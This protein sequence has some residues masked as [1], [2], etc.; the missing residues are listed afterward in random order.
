MYRQG[1]DL[2]FL[3]DVPSK[4]LDALDALVGIL[5]KD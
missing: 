4:H 2:A 3:Q 1:A 5:T